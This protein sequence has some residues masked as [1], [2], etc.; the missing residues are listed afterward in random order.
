MPTNVT[1]E[2][3]NAELKYQKARTSE[4]KLEALQ[5]ML[6]TL[7]KHKGTEVLKMQIRDRMKRIRKEVAQAKKKRVGHS[8]VV[9]KE[10][11]QVAVIGFPN[12]GKSTLLARLTNARPKISDY[13]FTTK[14]PEVGIMEFEGGKMQLVEIPALTEGAAEK[15]RELMTLLSNADGIIVMADDDYQSKIIAGE[16]M[17][18]G[19]KKPI[20]YAS[21]KD[22]ITP[23]QLFEFFDLIRVYTKEPGE[24]TEM[25]KPVLLERG[26][27]VLDVAKE[28]HKDFASKLK[29]AKVWGSSKFPG[30]RVEKDYA[31]KDKDIVELHI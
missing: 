8:A 17:K 25:D 15:Q 22:R 4:E 1:R 13:P 19:I 7:P 3:L 20:F 23:K 21:K 26:S 9:K 27:T 12:T 5:E 18:F 31:L 16:L 14:K 2:Y 29:F 24:K 30:Q 11:F 28:I 6:S 10:G